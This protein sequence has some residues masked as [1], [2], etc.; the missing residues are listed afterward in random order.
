MAERIVPEASLTAVASPVD[1]FV[2]PVRQEVAEDPLL[3]LAKTLEKVNPSIQQVLANRYTEFAGREEAKGQMAADQIDPAAALK[4]NKDGWKSLVA[5]ERERDRINGTRN[6]DMLAAAS[7]HFRRGMIK[8]KATRMGLGLNDFLQQAYTS[9]P[10]IRDSDDQAAI[11]KW[12]A[13]KTTQ[14]AESVGLGNIDPLLVAEV[15]Q[16]IAMRAQEQIASYHTQYRLDRTQAEYAD[17]LSANS[18]M[19]MSLGGTGSSSQEDWI[20]RMAISESGGRYNIVNDEGYTG[21][22]QFGQDR[23]TDY[24]NANGTSITLEEFKNSP[25]IQD[26]VNLWHVND[27]DKVIRDGGYLA[28][29]YSLD[30]LRAVAHLGGI[31]GMKEFVASEGAYNPNDSN[32]T[33]LTDYYRKFAGPALDLQAMLDD[34]TDN[35]MDPRK[36]NET[37]VNSVITAALEARDPNMLAVLDGL[38]TGAGPLGNIGWV[39]EARIRAEEQINDLL[40]QEETRAYT[41]AERERT[42]AARTISIDATRDILNNPDADISVYQE[43]ALQ[44]GNPELAT[45]IMGTQNSVLDNIFNVRTNH[46]A[47]VDLRY[48]IWETK[49]PKAKAELATEIL[50]GT[51]SLWGKSDAESLMDALEQSERNG[52]MMDDDIVQQALKGLGDNIKG[53]FGGTDMFGAKIGAESEVMTAQMEFYDDFADWLEKNPDASRQDV[54]KAAREIAKGILLSDD[55]AAPADDFSDPRAPVGTNPAEFRRQQDASGVTEVDP[56]AVTA[57]EG[58]ASA[59]TL[60]APDPNTKAFLKTEQ[61]AALLAQLAALSGMDMEEYSNAIGLFDE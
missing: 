56:A 3:S 22:L 38:N 45:A 19:L 33:K 21:L 61:G 46:E 59:T 26:A 55:W 2:A 23:L 31:G 17:E 34:A 25:A 28:K 24:N 36:A 7:P 48:R 6:G 52:D 27:I 4:A 51:G 39:K 1:R 10:S 11:Q 20:K 35:L 58:A 41:R 37:V 29:G 40:Y 14:Y 60:V 30:G 43:R 9:D 53:R 13:E 54:R 8:A 44:S 5:Q 32:G 16:P 42:E 18:G 57:P 12:I 15:Y 50:R 49:D 47:Y